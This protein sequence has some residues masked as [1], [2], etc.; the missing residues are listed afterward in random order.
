MSLLQSGTLAWQIVCA[1]AIQDPFSVAPEAYRL[2]FENN[3]VR[4]VRVHYEPRERISSHD[5]PKTGT[6]YVYLSN[7]G[8]VRFKHTGEEKFTM[9]R[10]CEAGAAAAGR[11]GCIDIRGTHEGRL[12]ARNLSRTLRVMRDT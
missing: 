5:H 2:Q 6:V 9:D 10:C 1:L 12:L 3:W 11:A 8:P 7:S 4:V